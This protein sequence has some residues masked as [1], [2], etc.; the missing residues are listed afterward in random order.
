M[1]KRIQNLLSVKPIW[2]MLS[3][4]IFDGIIF[5]F[6]QN[7]SVNTRLIMYLIV[8]VLQQLL[9]LLTVY[10]ISFNSDNSKL[11]STI[12]ISSIII[13]ALFLVINGS[14]IHVIL[15]IT[16]TYLTF[17]QYPIASYILRQICKKFNCNLGHT[18]FNNWFYFFF[19]PFGFYLLQ[20]QFN[21]INKEMN[22]VV[23]Q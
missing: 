9:P 10:Y 6:T 21:R 17:I 19:S 15:A 7:L 12:S 20:L 8:M 2:V 5:Y 4:L 1:N 18:A 13:V 22:K 14:N 11:I 3:F 23:G 16:M